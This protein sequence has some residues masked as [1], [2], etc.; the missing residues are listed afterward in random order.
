MPNNKKQ[1]QQNQQ[2]RRHK[3]RSRQQAQPQRQDRPAQRSRV[4]HYG[5]QLKTRAVDK[6]Y[7]SALQN[8]S[9]GTVAC[10][11]AI[12]LPATNPS[13]RLPSVEMPRTGIMSLRDMNT[14]ETPSGSGQLQDYPLGTILYAH[15]GQPG[16]AAVFTKMSPSQGTYACKFNNNGYATTDKNWYL[17]KSSL[18]GN[19][20]F[21]VAQ[22]WPYLGADY[23]SGNQ[24][25]G[26]SLPCGTASTGNYIFMNTNDQLVVSFYGNTFTGDITYSLFRYDSP[27]APPSQVFTVNRIVSTAAT[28]SDTYTIINTYSPGHYAI[29]WD[30]IKTTTSGISGSAYAVVNLV[31]PASTT[32]PKWCN[33]ALGDV[34]PKNAGDINLA[35]CA[36]VNASSFL[37]SNTTANLTKQGTI[38]AA[39]VRDHF[40]YGLTSVNL[41]KL[42]E[43]YNDRAEKGIYS[44]KEFSET[45]EKFT[46]NADEGHL[47]YD[48]DYPGYYH[49]VCIT[50]PNYSTAP[51]SY[52]L[53]VDTTLE[54]RTDIARYNKGVSQLDHHELIEARRIINSNPVWFYENPLHMSDIYG[55]MR[56]GAALA[57]QYGPAAL[58]AA[59]ILDPGRAAIYRTARQL[60]F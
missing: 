29:V 10:A 49:F 6:Y 59:A 48:L 5:N 42:A 37:I 1:N 55:F 33:M 3:R 56:R 13:V 32:Q 19:D 51:N 21:V 60:M 15:Y 58:D 35:E 31:V 41:G 4:P 27:N 14:L 53:S 34:D 22:R 47:N 45:E 26:P 11:M 20:V 2:S 44:F 24:F 57:K 30:E 25:H 18:P 43:K 8:R 16:R 9:Q 50:N 46:N 38:I 17:T 28:P 7:G 36:R 12:A 40:P 52:T 23:S 39:R 54:F